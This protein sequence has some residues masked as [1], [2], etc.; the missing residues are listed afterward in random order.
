MLVPAVSLVFIFNC[1]PMSGTAIAFLVVNNCLQ[2]LFAVSLMYPFVQRF[3]I[4][5]LTIG[6]A[7]G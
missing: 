1:V 5:G 4:K 3:F 7:K 6:A 2:L